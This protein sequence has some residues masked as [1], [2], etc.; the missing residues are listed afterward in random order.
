ME[1]YYYEGYYCQVNDQAL[2]VHLVQ[3]STSIWA[4]P[5]PHLTPFLQE[6]VIII[7]R[8]V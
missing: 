6:I 8:I 2:I 1:I 3:V 7:Y 4:L 5:R